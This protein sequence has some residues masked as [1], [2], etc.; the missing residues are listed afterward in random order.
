MA[1]NIW[2][3]S[4]GDNDGNV[5]A[6]WSLGNV[7]TGTDVAVFDSGTTSDGCVFSAPLSCQGMRFDNA[8]SGTVDSNNQAITLGS[9]GL[10]CTGGGSA[11]IDMGSSIWT[12]SGDCDIEDIGTLTAGTS[13]IVFAGSSATYTLTAWWSK[14][15]YKIQVNAT[16]TVNL[17][18]QGSVS[19]QIAAGGNLIVRGTLNLLGD[20][21]NYIQTENGTNVTIGAAGILSGLGGLRMQTP[22]NGDGIFMEADT[23]QITLAYIRFQCYDANVLQAG[24]YNTDVRLYPNYQNNSS[25]A[26]DGAY[27]FGKLRWLGDASGH[28]HTVTCADGTTINCGDLTLSSSGSSVYTVTSTGNDVDWNIS[29][30]VTVTLSGGA[31]FA[32]NRGTGTMTLDST[33]SADQSIDF[34]GK[35]IETLVIDS[36][37]TGTITF[38]G[39]LTTHSFTGTNGTVDFN[40]V[41]INCSDGGG[42]SGDMTLSSGFDIDD[43]A[44]AMNGATFWVDGAFSAD[45]QTFLATAKWDL[46]VHGASA[47]MADCTIEYCDASGAG[48]LEIDAT[49][50][51]VDGEDNL[52]FNFDDESSSSSM[53]YSS[54]SSSEGLRSRTLMGLGT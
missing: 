13:T 43:A 48:H 23:G 22:F 24:V 49:D 2:D 17:T 11:T 30:D 39:S 9:S 31:A 18:P 25:I 10:D 32:W 47:V 34:D 8:Y 14:K 51:C 16:N 46:E 1:D 36:D 4:D 5:A 12:I 42:G 40:D 15:P 41:T 3:N 45:G 29:G 37:S 26:L 35:S 21:S 7:P 19:L 38:T 53:E 28:N 50:N 52:N 27:T 44:D 33:G 6:N 20:S 54:S